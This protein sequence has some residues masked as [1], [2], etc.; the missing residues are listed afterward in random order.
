M[1]S[2]IARHVQETP[3]V[4]THEHLRKEPDWLANTDDILQDI[5]SNYVPA[6]LHTAGIT[7]EQRQTLMDGSNPDIEGR[8]ES[9][10][11]I[12][13]KIQFTGYGEAV[14]IIAREIYGVEEMTGSALAAQNH[15]TKALRQPGERHRLLSEVAN[16]DHIQTD[17]F[18]WPCPPDP[19][20]V[21]FFMY[22]LSWQGF[23]SGQIDPEAIHKETGV[24]VTDVASL[25]QGMDAIFAKHGPTAIA[26]KAQHAYGRTLDWVERSD[27]DAESALQKILTANG[28]DIDVATRLQLGDWCWSRGVELS[29]EYNLP[30]KL[31]TGY[32]AGNDRMPV[33]RIPS[34][35][36]AP[37]LAKYLDAKFVLMHIS[38]PYSDELV[39]MT[40]HYR[41]VWA[42]LCWA[43]SIDP[44]SSR[45]FLR[46]CIH[47][48]PI[49]KVFAFGGD[50]G[51]PTSSVAYAI[52]ARNEITRALEAEVAEGYMGEKEAKYIASRIMYDNQYECFDVEGTRAA[53]N[54][55]H[56]A[57]E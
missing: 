8:F 20:G 19:S 30:F 29:I 48:V 25:K 35:N 38:Y 9:V 40:K 24:S 42:D 18:C 43:W 26:V 47:A 31:H 15:K 27:A 21:E 3:L 44:Y 6:D 12:W 51:W 4:D 32:Y 53:L 55:A 37:L 34:G 7:G 10:R 57:A 11:D 49:N 52:Q 36:L 1:S 23:C 56:A 14:S 50:T 28:D 41:N 22:D 39:A 16:L 33:R 17:D 13:E 45:D 54:A 5:F 2:D 46:R